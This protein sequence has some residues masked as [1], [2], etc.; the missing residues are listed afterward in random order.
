MRLSGGTP[1]PSSAS[2]AY[3]HRARRSARSNP[4]TSRPMAFFNAYMRNGENASVP[5]S[6][7]GFMSIGFLS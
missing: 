3:T 1:I 7:T 2:T 6:K 5:K 4:G